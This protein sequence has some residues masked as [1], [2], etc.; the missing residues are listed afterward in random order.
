MTELGVFLPIGNNGWILSETSPQYLPT[1]ELNR[2][3]TQK[4]EELGFGFALSMVKFRGYGGKTMHWDYCMDSMALMTGL[5][6]VTNNIRLYASVSPITMNPAIVARMAASIDDISNGRFGINIVAG[7]NRS[8]YEQMGLWR[9]EDFYSY[10][11]DYA[12][13]FMEVMRQLWATGRC[14]FHGQYFDFD[15]CECLPTPQHGVK[16]VSAGQSPRGKKFI[17]DYADFHFGAGSN[18]EE[19]QKS[20]SALLNAAATTQRK[21]GAF[22]NAMIVLGDTDA[23]AMRKVE[24]YTQG[25]DIEAIDFVTG[26]YALDTAK[27]GSSAAIVERR[28][29]AERVSPFYGGGTPMAGSA[30]TVA[31]KLDEMAVVKGTDGI[32]LTFDDFVEGLDRFGQEVMPLLQH[33]KRADYALTAGANS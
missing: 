4:A 15:D 31:R 9:G 6:A 32:M 27:D 11:Y 22:A 25:A 26:Q 13:E 24:L 3:I 2:T 8:E 17:S 16:I 20:N 7:W 21:V 12:S 29:T 1:F 23:D 33:V 14:T 18:Q 5:A 28:R 30:E 10:R 19:V